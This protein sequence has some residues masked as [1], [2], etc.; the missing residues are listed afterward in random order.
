MKLAKTRISL[1]GLDLG[2]T[3]LRGLQL[4]L[5][6]DHAQSLAAVEIPLPRD[7]DPED[8][9][10]VAD[11]LAR[12]VHNGEFASRDAIIHCPADRLDLRPI[13][14]PAGRGQLPRNAVLGALRLQ[15][16]GQLPFPIDTAVFDYFTAGPARNGRLRLIAITADGQWVR[17]RIK[18]VESVGLHCVRVE[19]FPCAI[20]RLTASDCDDPAPDPDADDSPDIARLTAILDLG[21]AGSTLVV[22]GPYGPVFC[23][24]FDFAGIQ[25]IRAL[26]DRLSLPESIAE[27]LIKRYGIDSQ[28]RKLRLAPVAA[29]PLSDRSDTLPLDDNRNAEIG[30]TMYAALT[31]HLAAFV[32]GLVRSLNYVISQEPSAIL[33]R[34]LLTGRTA[35]LP[36]LDDYLAQQFELPVHRFHASVIDSLLDQLPATRSCPGSWTTAFAL[37][38]PQR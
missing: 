19:A 1:I 32:E 2:G 17:K 18:L 3:A 15:L 21:H 11:A 34:V 4:R 36:N 38:H 26:T 7:H 37:V 9:D 27:K 13:D 28:S 6:P 33:H 12:L 14:L 24:R 25:L 20:A 35:Q 30:K 16:G 5:R 31:P 23:R 10:A 22:V 8:T 29:E